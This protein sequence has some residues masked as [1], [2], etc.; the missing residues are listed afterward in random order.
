ML[1][2]SLLTFMLAAIALIKSTNKNISIFGFAVS[3]KVA[4]M[5]ASPIFY[6]ISILALAIIAIIVALTTRKIVY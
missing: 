3:E 6:F 4:F 5:P 2:F 1:L